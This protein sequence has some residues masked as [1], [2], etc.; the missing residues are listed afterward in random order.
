[1]IANVV[2]SALSFLSVSVTNG[3]SEENSL[4]I[5]SDLLLITECWSTV[6][7]ALKSVSQTHLLVI[8]CLT[9]EALLIVERWLEVCVAQMVYT[10]AVWSNK[11]QEA[12]TETWFL[13]CCKSIIL[14]FWTLCLMSLVSG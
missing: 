6:P 2:P 9:A 10:E 7:F 3:R 13:L 14:S 12:I 4:L 5:C 1:M 8:V 11:I